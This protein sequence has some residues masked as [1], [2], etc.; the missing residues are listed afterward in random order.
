MGSVILGNFSS[1]WCQNASERAKLKSSPFYF[2]VVCLP[3]IESFL[4]VFFIK[5]LCFQGFGRNY[6]LHLAFV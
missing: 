5:S 3:F 6:S 4:I 1:T 2:L